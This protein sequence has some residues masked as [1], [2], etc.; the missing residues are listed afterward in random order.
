VRETTFGLSGSPQKRT[1]TKVLLFCSEQAANASGHRGREKVVLAAER[2]VR[3]E[4][5]EE[6]TDVSKDSASLTGESR[7]G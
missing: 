3:D 2:V 4:E 1:Q 6:V 5:A 7:P